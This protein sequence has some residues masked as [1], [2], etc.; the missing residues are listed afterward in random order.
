MSTCPSNTTVF[1]NTELQQR[2][3]GGIM[4][5]TAPPD[6]SRNA[7]G[8]L[9]PDY[10]KARIESLKAGNNALIPA[11]PNI[12]NPSDMK[13]DAN[14][15]IQAYISKTENLKNIIKSEYCH[16]LDRYRFAIRKM[17]ESIGNAT[18][19]G[20]GVGTGTQGP[21]IAVAVREY[22]DSAKIVNM[23]LLDLS[24]LA[25]AIT[26]DQYTQAKDFNSRINDMNTEINNYFTT[27]RAHADILSLIHI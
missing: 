15:S 9:S 21:S 24:Q 2:Y 11:P 19:S 6:S 14:V 20:T 5:A 26:E 27:L 3:S 16:Y 22:T 23:A 18:L 1:S 13:S 10:L 12:P 17:V 25:N 4:E 8:L 7:D